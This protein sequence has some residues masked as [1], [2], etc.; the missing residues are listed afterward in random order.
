MSGGN[1]HG[2]VLLFTQPPQRVVSLVPSMTESL[3]DLGLGA[4]VV[5]VTDYCR[6]PEPRPSIGGTRDPDLDRILALTPDLV[7]ANQEENSRLAVEKLRAAGL[8]CWLTFPRSM[9]DAVQVLWTLVELFRASHAIPRLKTLEMT[10]EWTRSAAEAEPKPRVFVPIWTEAHSQA[11]PWWMSF[12]CR[13]YAHDVL[14][15]CGGENVCAARE[16]RYPLAADLGLAPAEP[17]GERDVRYPRLL[18]AEILDLQPEVIL[19]PD[20]PY[21]FG[22]SEVEQLAALLAGTPAVQHGRVLRIQGA[23]LAWHGTH[24]AQ[25]LAELPSRLRPAA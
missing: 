19:I 12:N 17:A 20:E 21:P 7:I 11:G 10:L 13:T 4:S 3:F 8:R 1:G 16:R 22:E 18:P 2:D 24:M 9:A 23:L 15:C 25:A 5:G 6:P 14:A